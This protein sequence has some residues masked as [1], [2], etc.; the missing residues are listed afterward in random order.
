M[1]GQAVEQQEELVAAVAHQFVPAAQHGA[2]GLSRVEQRGVAGGVAE[3]VVDLLEVVQIDH[4]QGVLAGE[5][6]QALVVIAAVEDLGGGVGI[7]L[8]VADQQLV[9]NI[10][11]AAADHIVR[12]DGVDAFQ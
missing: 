12:V 6:A 1:G 2:H 4:G 8:T 11:L 3:A 9:Q 7:H 10:L 5:A